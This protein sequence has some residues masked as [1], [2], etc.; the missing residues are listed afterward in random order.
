[1][2]RKDIFITILVGVFTALVWISV[3]LRLGTFESLLGFKNAAWGL[4][5]VVPL[6]YIFGLYL[7]EWLSHRWAFF[8]SF[9]R[10]VMIGFFNSGIDFAVFNFLMFMTKIDKGPLVSSFKTISFVVAVTNS[11]F[12]NKFWAFEA[13]ESTQKKSVEFAKFILVNIVG[14]ILNVGITSVIIFT[15]EPQLGFSQVVWNNLAAVAATAIA[16]IWNFIGFRLIVFKG[17]GPIS[18]E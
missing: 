15:I 1:M 3:F 4:V 17:A 11:Y 6:V 14:A 12:W 7:G 18:N 2:L 8:K 10:Y 16:L 13:G 5:I 9:A